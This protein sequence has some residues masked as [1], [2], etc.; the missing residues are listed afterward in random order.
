VTQNQS[1]KNPI[2]LSFCSLSSVLAS[3]DCDIQR[4][5]LSVRSIEYLARSIENRTSII[6]R[7]QHRIEESVDEYYRR[8]S[9]IKA[10]Q[11][12]IEERRQTQL[13]ISQRKNEQMIANQQ[14]VNVSD[15][16]LQNS[17]FCS[18]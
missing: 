16:V 12:R 10:G 8:M 1:G 2:F 5:K 14:K 17:D 6:R 15:E 3:S 11:E 4:Q 9:K 13:L 18:F 7:D